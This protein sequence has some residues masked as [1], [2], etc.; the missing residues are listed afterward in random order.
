MGNRQSRRNNRSISQLFNPSEDQSISTLTAHSVDQS[1]DQLIHPPANQEVK[2][3][4][5]TINNIATSPDTTSDG[6]MNIIVTPPDLTIRD[7]IPL[8]RLPV[9]DAESL[10]NPFGS[11]LKT[12]T[13][14]M[15]SEDFDL[16]TVI[17][18]GRYGKV[19]QVRHRSTGRI[20][21]MKILRKDQLIQSNQIAHTK[22]ER[23]VLEDISSPFIISLRYAFQTRNKLFLILDY[24]TGGE[25]FFHLKQEGHFTENRARF[26]A[27]EIVLALE[28]LHQHNI[29]YR[30]LKVSHSFDQSINPTN[31]QITS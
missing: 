2:Q 9:I 7:D 16:L 22:T 1:P 28:V 19:M 6:P 3:S 27:A 8:D 4:D 29:L 11:Q 26:Y 17:G 21:A 23:Q 10:T 30:D 15:K 12:R 14:K 5:E 25:L 20:F 31:T 24:V 13:D 18:V